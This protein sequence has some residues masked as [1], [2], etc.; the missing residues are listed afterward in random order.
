MLTCVF[1][2]MTLSP[3]AIIADDRWT[4]EYVQRRH[5]E[6]DTYDKLAERI[7]RQTQQDRNYR[8]DEKLRQLIECIRL[9]ANVDEARSIMCE[10]RE[11]LRQRRIDS[12]TNEKRLVNEGK[13]KGNLVMDSTRQRIVTRR[14]HR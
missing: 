9:Q 1:R 13:T 14:K 11:T 4:Q 10:Q 7:A 12:A 3:Q 2:R 6:C 5:D 8:H